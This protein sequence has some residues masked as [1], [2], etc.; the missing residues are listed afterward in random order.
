LMLGSA[1]GMGGAVGAVVTVLVE[2]VD[3][4]ESATAPGAACPMVAPTIPRLTIAPPATTAK[5]LMLLDVLIMELL[6]SNL[7]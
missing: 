6:F 4:L 1:I 2:P 3:I 7:H 5:V